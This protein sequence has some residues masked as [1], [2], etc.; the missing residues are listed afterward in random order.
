MLK[1]QLINQEIRDP[2]TWFRHI[3]GEIVM[4]VNATGPMV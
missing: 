4:L 2:L 3:R 1:I